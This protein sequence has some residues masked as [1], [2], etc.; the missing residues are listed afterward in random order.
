M[1][2]SLKELD[3][4]VDAAAVLVRE[5]GDEDFFVVAIGDEQWVDE[6]GLGIISAVLV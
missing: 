5:R 6:H 2:E 4:L 3:Y 1:D